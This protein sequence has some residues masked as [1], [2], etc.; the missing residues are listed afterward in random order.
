[1]NKGVFHPIEQ[2]KTSR[3]L[4][5][6]R[7]ISLSKT[8]WTKYWNALLAALLWNDQNFKK[9]QLRFEIFQIENL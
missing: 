2:H 6:F 3:G 5:S 4:R 7:N 8:L 9:H 1:M